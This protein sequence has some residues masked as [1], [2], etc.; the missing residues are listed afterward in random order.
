[1]AADLYTVRD[2]RPHA[3]LLITHGVLKTGQRTTRVWWR[4]QTNWPPAGSP[5]WCPS[6][7]A[8]SPF[9][10]RWEESDDIVAAFRFPALD[11]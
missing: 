5:S 10:W 1:M 3:G 7:T 8:S 6:S 9:G 4:W 2:G 11:G